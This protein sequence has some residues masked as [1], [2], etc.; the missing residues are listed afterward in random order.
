MAVNDG[1]HIVKF[2]LCDNLRNRWPGCIAFF[3]DFWLHIE[4]WR[5]C[6]G[7]E[8]FLQFYHL[9]AFAV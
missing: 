6:L 8:D 4:I 7:F 2:W 9:E 1:Q 5:S 3:V